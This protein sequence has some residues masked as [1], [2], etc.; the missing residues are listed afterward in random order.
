MEKRYSENVKRNIQKSVPFVEIFENPLTSDFIRLKR[1]NTDKKRSKEHYEWMNIFIDKLIQFKKG[2]I[3]GAK[4]DGRLVAAVFVAINDNRIYYLLPVSNDEGKKH[5]AMFGLIDYIMGK[6][7]NS[8]MIFDFEGSNI[9][10]VAR[11]FAGFGG[12][13]NIYHTVTVNHLPFGLKIPGKL[14]YV[15]IIPSLKKCFL[16][17]TYP[18]LVVKN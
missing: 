16:C 1:N 9:P 4:L 10:G 12:K 2:R 15:F 7:A 5:R 13:V 14:A 11:L 17:R 8:G 3:I 18:H 6:Y